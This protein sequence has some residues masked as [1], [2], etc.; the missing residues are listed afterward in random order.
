M[1]RIR[2]GNSVI[3]YTVVKTKRRKT[4]EIIVNEKGIEIR[5]PLTKKDSEIKQ[6]VDDKKKWIFKKKLEFSD[7][8]RK[9]IPKTKT[10]S[11]N[12][13]ETRTWKL[14]SR[15]EVKPSKVMIKKLKDRWGSS[16]KH[17]VINLNSALLE[18]P[19]KVID[20]VIIHELC[21]LKIKE[22]SHRYWNLVHKYMPRYNY[23]KQWLETHGMKIL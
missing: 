12:D 16:T 9:K 4:S 18:A 3:S 23:G 22:H 10:I 2:Y 5:T 20:Y 19:L 11:A 14:A 1:S 17:G 21:H 7:K 6:L 8:R 13:L 15:M